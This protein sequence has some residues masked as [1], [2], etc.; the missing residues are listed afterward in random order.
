MSE[1][2]DLGLTLRLKRVSQRRSQREVARAAGMRASRLSEIECGW[3][4]PHEDE[5]RR[6]LNVLEHGGVNSSQP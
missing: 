3:L 6:L 4:N 5:L 1:E 2:P